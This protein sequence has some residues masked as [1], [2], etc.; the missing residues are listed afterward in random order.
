M[1]VAGVIAV[2]G[3]ISGCDLSQP[4]IVADAI[5]AVKDGLKD[6][7]SAKFEQVTKCKNASMVTGRVNAKNGFGAYS[8]KTWFIFHDGVV[9]FE[10]DGQDAEEDQLYSSLANICADGS[11]QDLAALN[12]KLEE[13]RKRQ[14]A[15]TDNAY[16]AA[17]DAAN[18]A[19]AAANAAAANATAALDGR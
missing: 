12:K 3:L 14:S 10:P 16:R 15:E 7:D 17:M 9:H 2:I 11:D 19:M 8:G 13:D 5:A 6:P 18:E 1:R 4:K